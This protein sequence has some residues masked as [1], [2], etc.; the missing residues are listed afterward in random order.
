M[1]CTSESPGIGTDAVG[2][3]RGCAKEASAL[4]Q[5]VSLGSNCIYQ[6]SCQSQNTDKNALELLSTT[7]AWHLYLG[8]KA[9][10]AQEDNAGSIL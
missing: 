9:L 6:P 8:L 1:T 2:L 4:F 7:Y 3:G 5:E 10:I